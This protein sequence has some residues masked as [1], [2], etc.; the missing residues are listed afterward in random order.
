MALSIPVT[1]RPGEADVELGQPRRMKVGRQLYRRASGGPCTSS[2]TQNADVRSK[3]RCR[4]QAF[5][6]GE[7]SAGTAVHATAESNVVA[8]I[9]ALHVEGVGIVPR[10]QPGSAGN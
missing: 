4:H 1:R 8:R 2:S 7:G 5:G 10:V 9:Q 6:A 3:R